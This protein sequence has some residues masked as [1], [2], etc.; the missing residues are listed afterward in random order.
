MLE[1]SLRGDEPFRQLVAGRSVRG[2]DLPRDAQMLPFERQ[3]AGVAVG[4]R[5]LH[6]F[7]EPLRGGTRVTTVD[8]NLDSVEEVREIFHRRIIG[9]PYARLHGPN[10]LSARP[11]GPG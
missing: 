10:G 5:M 3:G 6:A 8:E 9:G 4:Q 2:T 1:V 7:E 11:V